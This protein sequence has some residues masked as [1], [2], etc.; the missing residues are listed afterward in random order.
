MELITT[1]HIVKV[2]QAART[3]VP[4][5]SALV[6]TVSASTTY[7]HIL[8]H[9]LLRDVEPPRQSAVLIITGDQDLAS[10]YP[11]NVI[12][13]T[14]QLRA[15]LLEKGQE[16]LVYVTGNKGISHYSF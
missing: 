14:K 4:Y 5:A 7:S 13:M 9:P 16:Y 1:P 8:K 11:V 3:A 2:R 6:Y 10:A 15:R 12:Q